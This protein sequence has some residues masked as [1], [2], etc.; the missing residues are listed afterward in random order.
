MRDNTPAW[1]PS[2]SLEQIKARA[3]TYARVR[4]FFQ[5]RDVMEVETPIMSAS[6]ASDPYLASVSLFAGYDEHELSYLHTSPEF[7][8]KRLLAAG[9]GDIYQICKTFRKHEFGQRHN[10]EFSMLE[11]YRQGFN[12]DDLM[13]EVF[14]LISEVLPQ[15]RAL[16]ILS[17]REAFGRYLALDPFS[18]DSAELSRLC[19]EHCSYEGPVLERDAYL[20]LLL[21]H[22]IEPHLG[23][24]DKAT[25]LWAYPASQAALAETLVDEDG[26][27][28]AMRFELYLNGL[29]IA[30]GYQELTDAIEQRRRFEFDNAQR[31]EM[32]IEEIP[33]DEHLIAA[34]ASGMPACSGVALGLDRL[35]MVHANTSKI[36]DV[37]AFPFDR[38]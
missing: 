8:M 3:E 14:A 32:G 22:Q 31:R 30:N 33:L 27:H 11:W 2:C 38:A 28:V 20:D 7:P 21:S 29:E 37:L 19:L 26:N 23:Q 35:L 13:A 18:C 34:L 24:G 6:T 36:Q 25:F 17:Y 12:L 1:Q 9:S 10:P 16:E 4:A 5:V 15:T